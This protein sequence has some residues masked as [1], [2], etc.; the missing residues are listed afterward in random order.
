MSLS[1]CRKKKGRTFSFCACAIR[2]RL[3]VGKRGAFDFPAGWYAYVGSAFGPGGLRGR[4][5]R[6]LAPATKPHWHIDYLRVAAP[7]GEVWYLSS[8][9]VYEHQWADTLHSIPGT[10]PPVPGF[11]ASDCICV[12]HLIYLPE[13]PDLRDFHKLVGVTIQHWQPDS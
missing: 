1:F 3:K 7:V 13:G 6:H 10:A 9:K 8:E 12:S 5:K 4:L 2:T 11:G